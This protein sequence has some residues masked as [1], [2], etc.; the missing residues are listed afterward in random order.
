MAAMPKGPRLGR[1]ARGDVARRAQ[2]DPRDEALRILLDHDMMRS[3][4]RIGR[5]R[6]LANQTV[7]AEPPDPLAGHRLALIDI[8]DY[9]CDRNVRA[10]VD[11]DRGGV[12]S[13]RCAPAEPRLAPEEQAEALAVALADRRVAVGISLGDT[14]QAIVHIAQPHRAAKVVFG[15][16]QKTPSLVAIVDLARN[17]VTRVGPPDAV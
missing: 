3:I 12:A 1:R 5:F 16:K 6:V 9:S 2:G 7:V 8:V 11:L 17:V 15:A 10:C 14:P 13:L 4:A